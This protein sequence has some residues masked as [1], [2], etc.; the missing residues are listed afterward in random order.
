MKGEEVTWG[1]CHITQFR[2]LTDD[3]RVEIVDDPYWARLMDT[4]SVL[5]K[6]TEEE[7]GIIQ[8]IKEVTIGQ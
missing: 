1:T 6:V 7:G 8:T 2:H 3:R 5:R 4:A